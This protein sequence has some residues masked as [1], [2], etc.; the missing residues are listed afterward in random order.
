[1]TNLAKTSYCCLYSKPENLFITGV[2]IS[3]QLYDWVV[4]SVRKNIL[5][6]LPQQLLMIEHLLIRSSDVC[7]DGSRSSFQ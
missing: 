6:T 3:A 2:S 7:S 5:L 1:M 4:V